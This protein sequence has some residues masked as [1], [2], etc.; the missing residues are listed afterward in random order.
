MSLVL[1]DLFLRTALFGLSLLMAVLMLAAYGRVRSAKLL[2]ISFGF[3][4]FAAKGALLV[5]GIVDPGAYR[6]F[7]VPTELLAFDFAAIVL[8]YAGTAKT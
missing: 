8:L 7:T 6:T 4:A 3:L 1:V 5:L 2:L